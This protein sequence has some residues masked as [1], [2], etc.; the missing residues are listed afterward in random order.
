MKTRIF[1]NFHVIEQNKYVTFNFNCDGAPTFQS[2]TCS[3]YPVQIMINELPI[4]VRTKEMIVCALWFGKS[5]PDMNALMEGFIT[6]MHDLTNSGVECNIEGE[7]RLIKPYAIC[8]CVDTVARA[9]MQGVCGHTG[10]FSCPWCLHP[11]QYIRNP[12]SKGGCVKFPLLKK[13]A[14]D[15]NEDQFFK[16]LEYLTEKTTTSPIN[17]NIHEDETSTKMKIKLL[18]TMVL[19]L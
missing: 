19:R 3:I 2:S 1:Y 12:S 11:G 13:M 18:L 8:C 5:K 16:C 10:H 15:R 4:E 17:D 6:T 9:S 14:E 7:A